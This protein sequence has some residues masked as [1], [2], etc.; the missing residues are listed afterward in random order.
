MNTH[1][2][3]QA[4]TESIQNISKRIAKQLLKKV[5]FIYS[6][7]NLKLLNCSQRMNN[8][9]FLE[10]E[11]ETERETER[12]TD[13]CILFMFRLGSNPERDR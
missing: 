2:I 4:T 13:K 3:V 10:R 7:G 5:S 11:T 1:P 9:V 8:P 6:V 12:D